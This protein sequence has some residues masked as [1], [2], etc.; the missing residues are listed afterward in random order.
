MQTSRGFLETLCRS[1]R[2]LRF[3]RKG[4]ATILFHCSDVTV[5]RERTE[6]LDVPD[7][8]LDL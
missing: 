1:S 4:V 2:N 7:L 3:P 6:Y 5:Y 8:R